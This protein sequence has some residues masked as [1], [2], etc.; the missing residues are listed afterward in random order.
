MKLTAFSI[1][2]LIFGLMANAQ[3]ADVATAVQINTQLLLGTVDT[4]ALIN[5]KVGDSEDY[6]VDLGGLPIN[7]TMHKEATKE[8]GN[9]IWIKQDLD[10]MI[11]KDSQEMLM[12]RNT[13]KVLKFV[14]NGKEEEMPSDKIE[15]ISTNNATVTVPA[16]T[17]KV[18]HIV[19]KS[20]QVPAIEI[21]E[22][23]R[24][25]SLDGTAK[26]YIDQGQIKITMELTKFVKQ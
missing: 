24:D 18:M 9:G 23:T 13:G 1:A 6:K 25:I 10:L 8:E 21:W 26:T 15:I 19:A 16:G 2:L 5:W 22:N 14:H 4:M 12:D 7:G 20:Q 17:F 11:Q 3:A